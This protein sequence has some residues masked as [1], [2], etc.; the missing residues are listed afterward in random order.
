M[1]EDESS[2]SWLPDSAILS[3]EGEA[4]QQGQDPAS[5]SR[6]YL[7]DTRTGGSRRLFSDPEQT[8]F[9]TAMPSVSPDGKQVAFVSTKR[10]LQG[11]GDNLD[12]SKA[13]L[14]S[15]PSRNG[16]ESQFAHRAE[17]SGM[18]S[19]GKWIAHWEGVEMIHMSPHTGQGSGTRSESR[20]PSTSGLPA[21]RAESEER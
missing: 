7:L 10:P 9:S 8:K 2:S 18:V 19:N 16:P 11:V 1:E 21:V 4:G 3:D 13:R 20:K 6:L 15:R 17:S 12:G 5:N 14:S